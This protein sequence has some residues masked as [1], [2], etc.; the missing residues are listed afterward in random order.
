MERRLF[1]QVRLVEVTPLKEQRGCKPDHMTSRAKQTQRRARQRPQHA[2]NSRR[3][4]PAPRGGFA[5]HVASAALCSPTIHTG[6]I[7]RSVSTKRHADLRLK[8]EAL[9]WT[10]M[11]C[12]P[13]RAPRSGSRVKGFQ[14]CLRELRALLRSQKGLGDRLLARGRRRFMRARARR[15]AK[16]AALQQR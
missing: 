14:R 1:L 8:L 12:S 11:I 7:K 6:A 5:E 9:K 2:R 4:L 3:A 15:Q 10:A 16:R 13:G